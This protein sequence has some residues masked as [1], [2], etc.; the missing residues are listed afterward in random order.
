M[1]T[2]LLFLIAPLLGFSQTTKNTIRYF[3]IDYQFDKTPDGSRKEDNK[4]VTIYFSDPK[5]LTNENSPVEKRPFGYLNIQYQGLVLSQLKHT[6]IYDGTSD[7]GKVIYSVLKGDTE[8]DIFYFMKE[9]HKV[10]RKTYNYVILIGKIDVNDM[11]GLPLY[12]TAFH[13]NL[14]TN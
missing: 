4:T 1:L 2:T 10:G 9:T 3:T 7:Q 5:L 6:I 8:Y 14:R 12:F 11:E 13:C